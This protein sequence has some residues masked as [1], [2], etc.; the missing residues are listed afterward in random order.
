M[1]EH[2][3]VSFEGFDASVEPLSFT[4]RE[5]INHPYR[6]D[7]LVAA[8]LAEAEACRAH[9]LGR[10]ARLTFDTPAGE[11]AIHGI[12]DRVGLDGTLTRNRA[13][14]GLRLVP[15]LDGLRHVRR[16]RVFENMTTRAIAETI[17]GPSVARRFELCG[18][19]PARAYTCQYRETDL[20]F[21]HR[22]LAEDGLFYW[23]DHAGET[24]TWI[25]TDDA[26]AYVEIAGD[27]RLHDA[28]TPTDS[29]IGLAEHQVARV[30]H[31]AATRPKRVF[32]AGRDV[33]RSVDQT[34]FASLETTGT[35]P[36]GTFVAPMLRGAE[37]H[38]DHRGS[39]EDG[40]P[41][42]APAARLLESLRRDAVRARGETACRRVEPGRRARICADGDD[43]EVVFEDVRHEMRGTTEEGR[44]T[45]VCVFDAVPASTPLRPP[46]RSV[47]PTATLETATVVTPREADTHTDD[48]GRVKV[49]FHWDV[50][51]HDDRL[52]SAWLRVSHAWAG[53][54]FGVHFLPRRGMEVLVSF[55]G[56]DPDRPIVLG[57]LHAGGAPPPFSLPRDAHKSGIRTRST[58][59][60]GIGHELVFDDQ[61][62]AECLS[63]RSARALDVASCGSANIQSG[64]ELGIATVGARTDRTG[65]DLIATIGGQAVYDVGDV[66]TVSVGKDERHSVAGARS[67]TVGSH[68][69]LLV[70]GSRVELVEG[71]R[72]VVVGATKGP[73]A[74]DRS[75]VT[76]RVL[77]Q[78]AGE[79]LLTSDTAIHLRCGDSTL[80]LHPDRIVLDAPRLQIQGD[81]RVA[82]VQGRGPEASLTL[83]DS[84]R[85]GG[86][87]VLAASREGANLE[88]TR[89]AELRGSQVNLG[90]LGDRVAAKRTVS[91][92]PSVARIEVLREWFP[93]GVDEVT[94]TLASPSGQIIERRCA[95]GQIVEL[96]GRSGE[97]FT[98][99]G[100]RGDDDALAFHA[101]APKGV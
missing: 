29:S 36:S 43:A 95:P 52:A 71:M 34:D 54:G 62:G 55:I 45:Y 24:E 30:R 79:M 14:L 12:V 49:R 47:R 81:D 78:A 8:D 74:D 13:V 7:V 80:S 17:V 100:I 41:V 84:V 73:P 90:G 32:R 53:A 88:L 27:P 65:G 92:D 10:R 72:N 96:E 89:V 64:G 56:G 6:F 85:I 70:R 82:L 11:R 59:G 86:A 38:V 18:E 19:L 23:F 57:A 20:T 98:V 22:I 21:L 61:S 77:R 39:A 75:S 48:L 87:S 35:A 83:E 1:D 5:R 37:V 3:V 97:A 40:R 94:L 67:T 25:I 50:E 33:S 69:Q 2:F 101:P 26:A 44:Q 63:L 51:E 58:P 15:A 99:V 9:L 42:I 66:L 60:G 76:G 31:R 68:D 91:D 4:G 16:S 28:A 93:P 46:P